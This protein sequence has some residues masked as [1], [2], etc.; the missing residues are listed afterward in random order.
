MAVHRAM[1][2]STARKQAEYYR[3]KGL[4][5]SVSKTKRGWRVYTSR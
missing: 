3:K 5:A 1:S 4:N 2:K